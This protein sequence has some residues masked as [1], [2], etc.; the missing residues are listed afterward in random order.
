MKL[1]SEVRPEMELDWTDGDRR[2]AFIRRTEGVVEGDGLDL[3]GLSRDVWF[4][5]TIAILALAYGSEP[6]MQVRTMRHRFTYWMA[7]PLSF[8]III[9]FTV[10]N[11]QFSEASLRKTLNKNFPEKAASYIETHGLQGPLYNSFDWGGYLIW[12]LPG[13]PVSIDGRANLYEDALAGAVN[14]MK[15]RKD[16]AQDPDFKKARTIL[17]EQDSSLVTVLRSDA[18][19]RLLYEDDMAAVFQPVNP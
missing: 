2:D 10:C 13:L 14:T 11:D 18:H 12:R 3:V 7:M 9:V 6:D 19:Y 4:P 5:V 15:G 16:W 17:L 1:D 8:L